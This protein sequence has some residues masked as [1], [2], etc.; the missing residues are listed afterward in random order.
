MPTRKV[1][2]VLMMRNAHP[3]LPPLPEPDEARVPVEVWHGDRKVTVYAGETV[4]RIWGA[5]INSEMSEEAFSLDAVQRAMDW[6]Y[7][8]RAAV[9][10]CA[11]EAAAQRLE[12]FARV[13]SGPNESDGEYAPLMAAAAALR[14]LPV[15]GDKEPKE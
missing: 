8:D 6:L 7:A 14:A 5:N 2:Q 13:G 10:R 1:D 15:P 9:W 11:M 3:M 4:L 12:W